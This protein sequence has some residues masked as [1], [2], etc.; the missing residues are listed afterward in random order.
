LLKFIG[1]DSDIVLNNSGKPEF[2]SWRWDYF[3]S[4]LD[5]VIDFKREVYE[6]AL[7]EL[8]IHLP[9]D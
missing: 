8:S 1:K 7:S 9:K 3:W 4:S 2:D 5:K 6:R